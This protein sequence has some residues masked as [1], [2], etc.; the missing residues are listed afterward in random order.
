MRSRTNLDYWNAINTSIFAVNSSRNAGAQAQLETVENAI[1]QLQR[2]PTRNVDGEL[3]S[4]Q[5]STVNLFSSVR[6]YLAQNP[7][8]DVMPDPTDAPGYLHNDER[9]LIE[10][11]IRTRLV[12]T[13]RYR[14]EFPPV[15]DRRQQFRTQP[16]YLTRLPAGYRDPR[17]SR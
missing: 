7:G 5:K 3:I 10:Q 6:A 8:A 11:G 12:L 16:E 13:S 4:L 14:L 1:D 17:I 2:I 15:F 9:A